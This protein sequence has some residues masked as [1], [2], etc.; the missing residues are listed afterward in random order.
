M[1]ITYLK[2]IGN[3]NHP[4][5]KAEVCRVLSAVPEKY[6]DLFKEIKF[7]CNRGS[8]SYFE[9]Y[10]SSTGRVLKMETCLH[11]DRLQYSVPDKHENKIINQI[12]G[13][14]D[15]KHKEAVFPG[16]SGKNFVAFIILFAFS[17]YIY[18][19]KT[20]DQYKGVKSEKKKKWCDN[21]ALELLKKIQFDEG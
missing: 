7:T 9:T 18:D 11:D 12:G 6:V 3:H 2:Q 1:R 19:D 17:N 4:L 10:Y 20:E 8:R 16:V 15:E 21:H 5:D 14:Y 13:Y